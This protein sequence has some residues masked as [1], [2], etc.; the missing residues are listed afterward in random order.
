MRY[1]FVNV[2]RNSPVCKTGVPC[3]AWLCQTNERIIN[4][5]QIKPHPGQ[6]GE[7]ASWDNDRSAC[8][9]GNLE[10]TPNMAELQNAPSGAVL[11]A[12][13]VPG[14]SDRYE[15]VYPMNHCAICYG[16]IP[17]DD[18]QRKTRRKPLLTVLTHDC[19]VYKPI[20]RLV[21]QFLSIDEI[22]SRWLQTHPPK[23]PS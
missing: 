6:D 16:F 22:A 13:T 20:Y 21:Q 5:R 14:F 4:G 9:K 1:T 8:F 19:P 10:D 7:E 3:T 23:R 17:V 18:G 12:I 15:S 11:H 2:D